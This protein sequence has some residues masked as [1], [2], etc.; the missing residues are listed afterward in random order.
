MNHNLLFYF[1][2]GIIFEQ[3]I[4]IIG[5]IAIGEIISVVYLFFRFFN[6]KFSDFEKQ[7]LFFTFSIVAIQ[8]ISDVYNAT[9][10]NKTLK[11]FST[12]IVFSAT[13]IFLCRYLSSVSNFNKVIYFFLGTI[14]GKII[15]WYFFDFNY[16]FFS[17]PWKWGIANS[18]IVGTYIFALKKEKDFSKF[19]IILFSIFITYASLI[20]NSRALLLVYILSIGTYF[21]I[22]QSKNYNLKFFNKKST[23]MLLP[24]M[25]VF[26][27]IIFGIVA[28]NLNQIPK[29]SNSF[30][31]MA[32]KNISEGQ[33]DFGIVVSSRSAVIGA[34]HAIKDKPFLG[35][36]SYP[37]DKGMK[38]KMKQFEFLYDYGYS[39]SIPSPAQVSHLYGRY[40]PAHSYLFNS[41]VTGGIFAGI[42]WLFLTYFIT[43]NY[44]TYGNY[45]P[46]IFHYWIIH[47]FYALFFSPWGAGPRLNLAIQLTIFI[48]Y[49]SSLKKDISIKEN[50]N[51][52]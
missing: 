21:I 26:I 9:S 39:S 7:L 19:F 23:F 17:N 32:Q 18:I 43:K 2:F 14:F 37:E 50:E 16:Y 34:F 24:F 51:I 4:I 27:T 44:V 25:Y 20:Y 41:M 49:L 12:Y 40:I 15:I 30:E 42:F 22:Y 28:T 5:Q 29:F 35:H 3:K 13:L 46:F 45:L 10:I 33:G 36:G 38:Y 6:L 11:G 52:K 31:K 47:Y 1:L 48:L 8:I